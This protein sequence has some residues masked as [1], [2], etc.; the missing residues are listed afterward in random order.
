MVRPAHA[1][2]A[3]TAS[4]ERL[5]RIQQLHFGHS[6]PKHKHCN[7]LFQ[8]SRN[9]IVWSI[10][11]TLCDTSETTECVNWRIPAPEGPALRE[12]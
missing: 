5:Q 7:L 12:A 1:R 3:S 4:V 10:S 6:T 2:G 11:E 9:V 8:R